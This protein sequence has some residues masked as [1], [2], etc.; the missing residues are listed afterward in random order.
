M[1]IEGLGMHELGLPVVIE[2]EYD[3]ESEQKRMTRINVRIAGSSLWGNILPSRLGDPGRSV[4][5]GHVK[6]GSWLDTLH[7]EV[8]FLIYFSCP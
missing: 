1:Q 8:V 4:K 6:R 2:A 7:V 3:E 5:G